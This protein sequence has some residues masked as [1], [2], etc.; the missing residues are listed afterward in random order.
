MYLAL[1]WAAGGDVY[2]FMGRKGG[3]LT[4]SEAVQVY[5]CRDGTIATGLKPRVHA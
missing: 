1:E 2:S 3:K 5:Y 4:E